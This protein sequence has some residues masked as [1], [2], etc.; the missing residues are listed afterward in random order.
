[1]S[2]FSQL[3]RKVEIFIHFAQK[4]ASLTVISSPDTDSNLSPSTR[5]WHIIEVEHI[6]R[7]LQLAA[8]ALPPTATSGLL[9]TLAEAGTN[10]RG[11]QVEHTGEEVPPSNHTLANGHLHLAIQYAD[12]PGYTAMQRQCSSG[13]CEVPLAPCNKEPRVRIY[14]N[15][16]QTK[17]HN[18]QCTE[19]TRIVSAQNF[20]NDGWH[21]CGSV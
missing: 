21:C 20:C 8:R 13:Q 17:V 7:A 12:Y 3:C 10:C 2:H 16:Q 15:N 6:T 11:Q 4:S 19:R 18:I 9:L 1:M 5:T 14:D